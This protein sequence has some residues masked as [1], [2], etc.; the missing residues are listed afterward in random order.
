MGAVKAA[1]KNISTVFKSSPLQQLIGDDCFIMETPSVHYLSTLKPK[2]ALNAPAK[3]QPNS[4][5]KSS[6]ARPSPPS[7][8]VKPATDPNLKTPLTIAQDELYLLGA[9]MQTQLNKIP[10]SNPRIEEIP[11]SDPQFN[12]VSNL[13]YTPDAISGAPFLDLE[14]FDL[15]DVSKDFTPSEG[16]ALSGRSTYHNALMQTPLRNQHSFEVDKPFNDIEA[17]FDGGDIISIP[18]PLDNFPDILR[19]VPLYRDLFHHFIHVTAD[20]LV[21]APALYPQNPFKTLLPPMALSTPHLL[22]LILAYAAAH[23]A[24]FLRFDVPMHVIS[25]L[26]GRVFQGLTK[27]L[28][29]EKEAQSDTTLTTAIMLSSYEI[30]SGT[31][32]ASWKKH[33]HGAR[34][35]VM[36]RGMTRPLFEYSEDRTVRRDS[37]LTDSNLGNSKSIMDEASIAISPR[38]AQELDSADLDARM[39]GPR[40]L[41]RMVDNMSKETDVSYFLI[42]WFAFIDVIGALSSSKATALLATNESIAQLWALHDWSLAR[43]KERSLEEILN[44]NLS[45]GFSAA[46]SSS[47]SSKFP[48]KI[49][50]FLGM[51]LDML[52]VFSKVTHLAR[53]RRIL[54][55][56]YEHRNR[57]YE[58]LLGISSEDDLD[59]KYQYRELSSEALELGD[60]I[61]SFCEAYELRRKQYV[62]NAIGEMMAKRHGQELN[63]SPSNRSASYE[64]AQDEVPTYDELPLQVQLYSQ[65]CVMNTT[66]CYSVLIQLYRRVLDLPT[67]HQLVQGVVRHITEL[68]DLY[69]PQG[70]EV[71]SSMSFPIFATACEVLDPKEREKYWLRMKKME[72]SAVSPIRKARETMELS[73]KH[74]VSWF[75]IMEEN[76]WD[77]VLA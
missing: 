46:S 34:D 30:L 53:E 10:P 57:E 45:G 22:D 9:H 41:S 27:S 71:E 43:L 31:G 60:L 54:K 75:D 72:R 20:L 65:L 51:D 5:S 68:L 6:T 16:L 37:T 59:P 7:S 17:D 3:V 67:S 4:S 66:F 2:S 69:I 14:D 35:I 32:D 63:S 12:V 47:S 58:Q 64:T 55:E 50:L 62:N 61:I 18:R 21:P 33:L 77:V 29:N 48:V 25:R 24:R 56:R 44:L 42:R 13:L 26:L 23:R 39:L 36:A 70:S 38:T 40:P 76:G 52:P 49:D 1:F 11:Q 28:E 8:K 19:D 74:N 15:Y 73:W